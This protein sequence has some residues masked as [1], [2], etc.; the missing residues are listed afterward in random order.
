M[1][2]LR[3]VLKKRPLRPKLIILF[4]GLSFLVA[5]CFQ[6]NQSGKSLPSELTDIIAAVESGDR[7]ALVEFLQFTRTACMDV[8]GL[9]GSPECDPNEPRGTIV[10]V[11]PMLGSEGHYLRK[12][13]IE[14][15]PGLE[16][17][18]LYAVY[19]VSD[20]AYSEENYPAGEYAL[21]FIDGVGRSTTLQIRTGKIVRIDKSFSDLPGIPARDVQK[22]LVPPQTRAP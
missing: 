7:H 4:C 17:A 16:I 5:S 6:T 18:R 13:Q 20:E 9:G 15:W 11:L 2:F 19:E 1:G 22:Y 3:R 10:E 14:S 8:Q 12:E 21:V